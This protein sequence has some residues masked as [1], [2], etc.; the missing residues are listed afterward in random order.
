[1]VVILAQ[2][3]HH[4]HMTVA[5][6]TILLLLSAE[7][8]QTSAKQLY[9][10]AL[11]EVRAGSAQQAFERLQ[12]V[13][14]EHP[15]D[16]FADDAL[17][18]QAR[19]TEEI[20]E[21]PVRAL[22]LYRALVE[23]YP[24][25]RL[26]RRAKKRIEFLGGHLDAGEDVLK[27]YM[28]IQRQSINVPADQT[29]ERM[30]RLLDEHKEFSL[31]PDG[32]H[33]LGSLMAREGM[34]AEARARLEEAIREYPEHEVAGL[35]L[36]LLGNMALEDGDLD[37]AEAVYLRL[38]ES[39]GKKWRKSA[40]D[41]LR[42]VDK[43]RWRKRTIVAA[44]VMWVMAFVGLWGL[45]VVRLRSR[46]LRFRWMPPAEAIG[47]LLVMAGLIAWAATGTRQTAR[48][49]LWMA[50][51]VF[52]ILV[53]NGWL[54]RSWAPRGLMKL[55]WLLG[56]VVICGAAIVAAIGLAGMTGQVLH[57]LQFGTD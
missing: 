9:Y 36:G 57:T 22:E 39:P 47:Y 42:R 11:Q 30:G 40:R 14:N 44:V 23:K 7:P 8:Q 20:L 48:A 2:P 54:L 18:E 35:A 27:E 1:M 3:C 43:L 56:L 5:V 25:S 21:Q 46:K 29:V 34:R 28:N 50:G 19:I 4:D 16:P 13:L 17:I 52:L 38:S 55:L 53:P 15:E 31:R 37:G 10:Q 51:M 12:Q 6:W 32:L 26:V 49:L 33:W 41:A 24:D 45:L